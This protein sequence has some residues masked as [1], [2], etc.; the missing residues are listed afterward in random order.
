MLFLEGSSAL[1]KAAL[2]LLGV[3]KEN[4]LQVSGE[5]NLTRYL[6]DDLPHME[7][8]Q[9]DRVISEVRFKLKF[10][11]LNHFLKMFLLVPK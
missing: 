7:D 5:E 4:L 2:C 6:K 11:Y 3:H 10:A 8:E 9:V 1:F